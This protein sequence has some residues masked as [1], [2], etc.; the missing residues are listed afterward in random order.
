MKN[1]LCDI[2][3]IKY[4]IFQG[5]MAWLGTAELAAAVSDA[6]GLGIIGCGNADADYVEEQIKKVRALTDKPF[7]VNV[8]L[9]SPYAEEIMDL[10][11]RE[12][13]SVVTTG[14]GNPGKYF[15]QL[16]ENGIK[17]IPVVP[18]TA[19]A[20]RMEKNGA[21]AIIVEGTEAGGHVGELTTFTLLPQ[22]A[23][24]VDIPV[25]AAGG[26]A[27]GRGL[28]ASFALGA[29][30]V[31][32]GTR[33]ICA[34]ECIAHENFK[35]AILKAKDRDAVITGRSTGHPV[36]NLKNAF[37]REFDKLEEEGTPVDELEEFGKGALRAAAIDGDDS[38]GSM[39][40]GQTAGMINEIKP[41]A[42]IIED[43]MGQI[44]GVLDRLNES[45]R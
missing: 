23:D 5:G 12:K 8:M 17:I 43:I 11:C 7:G 33:F 29:E 34:D 27:D 16:K 25:I 18:S 42:E 35:K 30:A 36:R 2:L 45:F 22:V 1:R 40:A 15:D 26:I 14:A 41:A 10:V 13:V 39:M 24:V 38:M 4:P 21:D 31:Q 20:K 44:D 19:L 37:T 28:V 9:L 32:I 6:G 3:N